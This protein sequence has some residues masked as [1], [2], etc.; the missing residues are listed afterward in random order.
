MTTAT[1]VWGL[2]VAGKAVAH[3]LSDRGE[4]VCVG[5]DHVNDEHRRFAREHA[6]EIVEPTDD[7][8]FD[9]LIGRMDRLSPAPGVP[10]T[11]RVIDAAKRGG[12][13]VVS[14][15]ELAYELE[16]AAGRHRPL[17]GITGTDGK[18]TTT[19]MTKAILQCAG[20]RAE[21]VGNTDV[22]LISALD[23]DAECFAVECSSFRL[24]FT[25]RFRCKA[26]V[27]L[28][29]APDHLDWHVDYDSYFSAKA[30]MWAHVSA[31]DVA[32]ATVDDESILSVARKSHARVVTFGASRGDYHAIDGVLTS[33]HGTIMEQRAMRRA[34]PHDVTNAL[35]AAA[36]CI[37]GGL[38][39]PAHVAEALAAFEHVAHRIEFIRELD[40][41]RWYNDSKA[42]SPHAAAV[43]IQS[44]DSIVLIAGGKNKGLDL[45]AMATHGD[46]VRAVVATG[47][48]ADAIEAAFATRCEVRRASSMQEAIDHARNLARSG[49]VVLLSPGC[50][51]YDW[52]S[53]YA[54]RGDDFRARVARLK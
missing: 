44:F 33:P 14:E 42:T 48:S 38:A 20:H 52:Y 21:A 43:A 12:R 49:D 54:E 10:E 18:T 13:P 39:Q 22:P 29:V 7:A 32:I 36:L 28:N 37:E 51:S 35:A 25:E 3:V 41:V 27:W 19:M 17:L 9:A 8:A 16:L 30:K 23:T 2:G 53:N 4:R 24:A 50:T 5:D 46:R 40:G 31:G 15:L 11:H 34:L 47:A 45:S 1:L 6:L 26:S